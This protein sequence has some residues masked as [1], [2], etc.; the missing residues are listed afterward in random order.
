[1]NGNKQGQQWL[2]NRSKW[3]VIESEKEGREMTCK[4]KERKDIGENGWM[5]SMGTWGLC[6]N[7]TE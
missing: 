5:I 7:A 6:L 4:G 3:T 2:A 1:M